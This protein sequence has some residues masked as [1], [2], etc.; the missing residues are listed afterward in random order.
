MCMVESSECKQFLGMSKRSF[1]ITLAIF[2]LGNLVST[3]IE[4]FQ[5]MS[6]VDYYKHSNLLKIG[7]EHQ[8]ALSWIR[9]CAYAGVLAAIVFGFTK[10]LRYQVDPHR[11]STE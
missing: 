10:W 7:R 8:S 11:E 4:I 2:F 1:C 9:F 3:F 6:A 5:W